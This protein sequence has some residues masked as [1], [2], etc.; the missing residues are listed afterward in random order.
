[1]DGFCGS[2]ERSVW[3]LKG[4]VARVEARIP[5]GELGEQGLLFADWDEIKAQSDHAAD[6]ARFGR[7][8]GD[9]TNLESIGIGIL[10]REI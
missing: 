5:L 1:M 3:A 4:D 8:V 10:A 7:I 2:G 6:F 9:P